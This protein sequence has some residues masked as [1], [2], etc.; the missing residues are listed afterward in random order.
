MSIKKEIERLGKAGCVIN[1]GDIEVPTPFVQTIK[2]NCGK[3]HL[4]SSYTVWFMPEQELN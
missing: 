3:F 4:Y 1:Y 2:R